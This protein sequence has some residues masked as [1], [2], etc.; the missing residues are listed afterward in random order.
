MSGISDPF[1]ISI[2]LLTLLFLSFIATN[3][4]F[5]LIRGI[6]NIAM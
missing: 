6:S 4:R 5:N 3:P 1:I 2:F